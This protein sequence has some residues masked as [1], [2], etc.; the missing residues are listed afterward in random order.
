M[1]KLIELILKLFGRKPP[2][3]ASFDVDPKLLEKTKKVFGTTHKFAE[4]SETTEDR[5]KK[6]QEFLKA[7]EEDP[8]RL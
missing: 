7:I 4:F 8:D 6:I 5:K 3:K 1:K 2:L